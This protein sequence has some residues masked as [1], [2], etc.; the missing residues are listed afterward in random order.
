ML[1][2]DA[3]PEIPALGLLRAR[4]ADRAA[5]LS[6]LAEPALQIVRDNFAAGGRPTPW[7]PLAE[8]TLRRRGPGARPLLDS[9]RLLRSIRAQL[10]GERLVLSTSLPY[11]AV[12]QFGGRAGRRGEATIPA[13]PYLVLPPT[14]VRRL[15]RLVAARLSRRSAS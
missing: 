1:R 11:A 6:A 10:K 8:S 9:G 7:A 5:L 12:Q 15:A 4:A 14:E 13:R 2:L 3:S